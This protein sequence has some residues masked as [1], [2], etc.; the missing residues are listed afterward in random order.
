VET[1]AAATLHDDPRHPYSAALAGARPEVDRSVPRL[2]A[3]PGRPVSAFEAPDGCAFAPRC[4]FAQDRCRDALPPL[5][6]V[7]G[8]EVRCARAV[9]L[10]GRLLTGSAHG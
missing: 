1:S 8:A 10:R 6:L 4:S 3:I 7:D 9:E 5:Q 2:A